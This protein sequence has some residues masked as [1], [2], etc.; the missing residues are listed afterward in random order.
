MLEKEKARAADLALSTDD[1][2][3]IKL[4][5]E[6]SRHIATLQREMTAVRKDNALA[7]PVAALTT[8]GLR[9]LLAEQRPEK[10]LAVQQL[11]DRR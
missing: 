4:V 5:A 8:E 11:I 9:E 3:F 1:E 2:V 6:K 7:D 10:A